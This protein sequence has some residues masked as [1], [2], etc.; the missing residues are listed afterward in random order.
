MEEERAIG[1]TH[2][3]GAG[4]GRA[5]GRAGQFFFFLTNER[6]IESSTCSVRLVFC[7]DDPIDGLEWG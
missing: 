2:K 7:S 3:R 4:E 6:Q 5:A 1:T